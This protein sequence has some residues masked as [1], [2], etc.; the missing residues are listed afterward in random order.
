MI[1]SSV[2]YL[3]ITIPVLCFAQVPREKLFKRLKN[4]QTDSIRSDLYIRIAND[5][6]LPNRNKSNLDSD[7]YYRIPNDFY[8]TDKHKV[9]DLD[10]AILYFQKTV[11]LSNKL[12]L[13]K[14]LYDAYLGMGKT[15]L[16][17]NNISECEKYYAKAANSPF[18]NHD[19]GKGAMVWLDLVDGLLRARHSSKKEKWKELS[20]IADAYFRKIK[21]LAQQ[22]KNDDRT[23][24]MVLG[25]MAIIYDRYRYTSLAEK[26][27]IDIITQFQNSNASN[28]NMVYLFLSQLYREHGSPDKALFYALKGLKS[29]RRMKDTTN[30]HWIY[31]EL[32][33]VYSELG[34]IDSSMT[35]YKR[36]LKIRGRIP[37][38]PQEHLY[39]TAGFI[40]DQ[41]NSQHKS[42]EALSLI[43]G[44]EKSNPPVNNVGKA[45]IAQVK[46]YCYSGLKQYKSAEKSYL[47]SLHLY[48]KDSTVS[49]FYWSLKC[50]IGEFYLKQKKFREAAYYLR[51]QD[52]FPYSD[53]T[54]RRDIQ[55][56][57][58]K[59]DSIS[60]HLNTSLR[61][62]QLYKLLNDS[63]FNTTKSKQI[64]ELQIK[65]AS[66]KQE[67]AFK[68]L[69]KDSQIQYDKLKQSDQERKIIYMVMS[70]MLALVGLLYYVYYN[71]RKKTRLINI[72]NIS[73]GR[74]ITEKDALLKEK[75]ILVK[76]VH[77]RVKNNLQ[78]VMSLLQ[79]QSLFI[80]NEEALMAIR[81]SE[82]RLYS[83]ALIHQKLYQSEN[84]TL[85]HMFEYI[86]ELIGYLQESFD[87]NGRIIFDKFV[88]K[89]DMNINIAVPLGLILNEAITNSIKY[90]FQDE[91]TARIK[92]IF[93]E[94]SDNNY[95]LQ[96]SDNGSG[97]PNGFDHNQTDS[98]GFNLMRGLSK[99]IGGK[100][101]VENSS[102][103]TISIQ[104]QPA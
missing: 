12:H 58:F 39:R 82:H 98:M 76:E 67:A 83:I 43:K 31:G 32:G 9:K 54:K 49:F 28:I 57:L 52:D 95:L 87:L 34:Q 1:K 7:I 56:L 2:L 78:I 21:T 13:N 63:I 26:Q 8:L 74:L 16:A 48:P 97:L 72:N 70:F 65:Y 60:G 51:A 38:L 4:A 19:P 84:Y 44:L 6:Y 18:I 30:T 50:D 99:Q 15:Y 41:L 73:L 53:I 86:N 89:S 3:L 85:V 23:S 92:I 42:I 77:H 33:L 36:A 88:D 90:A 71:N 69:Q 61:H 103:V 66:E 47:F 37:G 10:S 59:L 75:E 45:L 55:F 68:S 102:G 101:V 79:R 100:L 40:V 20:M 94:I 64:A 29:V 35:W 62:F 5:Y 11:L 25:D 91:K 104:F 22:I 14:R 24:I 27:Y 17:K 93:Q 96:I 80:A 81:N 46:A